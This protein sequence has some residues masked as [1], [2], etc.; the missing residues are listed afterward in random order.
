MNP[1]PNVRLKT[2]LAKFGCVV[3]LA[4]AE[5]FWQDCC[6]T[7]GTPQDVMFAEG[8]KLLNFAECPAGL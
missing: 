1:A 3:R 2:L 4:R 5:C 6:W 8:C 7:E